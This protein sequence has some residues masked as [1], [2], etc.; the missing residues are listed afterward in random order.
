MTRAGAPGKR[1]V[2]DLLGLRHD[3]LEMALVPKTLRIDLVD[4]FGAGGRAANQP[5][6]VTTFNPPIGALL[7][8]A[9]VSLA[10]IGSPASV[11]SLTASGDSFCSLAFCSGVAGGIDAR[12]IGRSEFRGQFAVVFPGILAGTCGDFGG[13]QVH[14]RTVFVG[15]PDGAILSQETR[16]GA[17]LTAEAA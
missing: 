6:A 15:R 1:I 8:G 14:D 7:P 13:E 5:L 12:V 2:Y 16:A 11:D 9:R 17:F 10:V 3:L 4:V